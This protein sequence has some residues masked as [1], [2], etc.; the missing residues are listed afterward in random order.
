MGWWHQN[1]A[2]NVHFHHMHTS[3]EDPS[4][5]MQENQQ[6]QYEDDDTSS[7]S[8][9]MAGNMISSDPT[10]ATTGAVPSS[11]ASDPEAAAA[12]GVTTGADTTTAASSPDLTSNTFKALLQDSLQKNHDSIVSAMATQADSLKA[13]LDSHVDD[14]KAELLGQ[15]KILADHI[16]SLATAVK[17]QSHSVIV[18]NNIH[19]HHDDDDDDYDGSD[20]S[21][22][23]GTDAFASTGDGSTLDLLK[24]MESSSENLS[25]KLDEADALDGAASGDSGDYEQ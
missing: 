19:H 21:D 18:E 16:A 6:A 8:S 2:G 3:D 23:I 25:H 24:S 10:D 13:A 4:Q 22:S 1:A 14:V 11:I 12:M 9:D 5:I 17:D 20:A 15:L 7:D